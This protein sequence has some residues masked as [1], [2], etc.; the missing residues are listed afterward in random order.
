[1]IELFRR[2][3]VGASKPPK[4]KC[5]DL[6]LGSLLGIYPKKESLQIF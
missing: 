4:T 6:P 5:F 1:M 2:R 3:P